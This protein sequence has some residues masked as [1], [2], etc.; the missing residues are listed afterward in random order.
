MPFTWKTEFEKALP[1]DGLTVWEVFS[2]AETACKKLEW[3][4]LIAD[5]HTFTASTPPNWTLTEETI[6]IVI[7]GDQILF[8]SQSES[9]DLYEAGKNKKN[10]EELLLPLFMQIKDSVDKDEL[11]VMAQTLKAQTLKQLKSGNRIDS[12]KITFGIKDHEVTFFLMLVNVVVFGIMFFRGVNMAHPSAGDITKWGGN[13]KELV[14]AGEWWRLVT[15]LF[16]QIGVLQLLVNLFGLYFIGIMVESILGRVKYLIAYLCGGTLASLIS[17]Y[18]EGGGVTAGAS[19]A[20]A[21][22]YGVFVAFATT[23]YINKKFNWSWF[24]CLLAYAFFNIKEDSNVLVDHSANLFGF[25]AGILIG[26]LFYFFHF[27]R[28]RARAGGTRISFEILGITALLIFLF[29]KNRENDSPAFERAIMKLNQI[30]LKAV[31][32]LQR[33]QIAESNNAAYKLL[34]DS[35]LPQWKLFQ[36]ELEKTDRYTL[37]EK[38]K[39]KRQLLHNYAELRYR[40]TELIYKSIKNETTQYDPEIDEVSKKIEGIIDELGAE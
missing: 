13:V 37:D 6:S 26:Y 10:I 39:L 29:I 30:E 38:F 8:K 35:T 5:E 28:N 24:V 20:I 23:S 17:I 25:I 16:V 21:A 7:K 4:Y 40:Q 33:L 31:T 9:I 14:A 34:R 19:A 12:E 1:I 27:R 18:L 22:M 15:N 36:K 3:E 2:I 11:K 32:Q